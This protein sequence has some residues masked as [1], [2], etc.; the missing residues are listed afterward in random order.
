PLEEQNRQYVRDMKAASSEVYRL[1]RTGI[2][3]VAQPTRNDAAQR[4]QHNTRSVV[5]FN[6][7]S[8][9]RTDLVKLP[10][11]DGAKVVAIKAADGSTVPFD[12]ERDGTAVFVARDVPAL[13]YA[14]FE[15]TTAAGASAS[16]LVR[17]AGAAIANAKHAVAVRA[18]GTV[19]S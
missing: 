9:D 13:G 17:S 14:S 4:Q 19:S 11:T 15:V 6:G 18:D 5:I 7:V 1:V 2:E 3:F 8:W 10:A 16:S 12:T